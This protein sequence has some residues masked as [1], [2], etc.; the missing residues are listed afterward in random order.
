VGF[1]FWRLL[2]F[3]STRGA[4]NVGILTGKYTSAPLYRL[5]T[6][7]TEWL[8]DL[9]DA[10]INAWVVPAYNFAES[11]RLRE[12]IIS[13]GLAL[14]A[15]MITLLYV[16]WV[17]S[18]NGSAESSTSSNPWSKDALIL[19]FIALLC[20]TLPVVV[21][22]RDIRFASNYDR[23]TLQSSLGVALFLGGLIFYLVRS[24]WSL[25]ILCLM[26]AS[27]IA[28]HYNNASTFRD[29]W[30]IE[31]QYWWQM[32]WRAP[33]IK[34]GT[35][36][37]PLFHSGYYI[38]EDY[39]VWAPANIIYY[40][41]QR[42]VT[43]Q[44]DLV[45]SDTI[46]KVLL[47]KS[48]TNTT[49]TIEYARDFNQSLLAFI[50]SS[51]SCLHVI[52]GKTAALQPGIDPRLQILSGYSRIDQIEAEDSVHTPPAEIFGN[53]PPHT[54]CYYFQKA[55]LAEQQG[56]WNEVARLGDEARI[57][58]YKPNDWSEWL[59]FLEG[60][61]YTGN[62]DAARFLIP[63]LQELPSIQE[64]TCNRIEDEIKG[65]AVLPQPVLEGKRYLLSD[66]CKR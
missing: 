60:Y 63:I 44:T 45:N 33:Q 39:E 22:D 49:R 35:V 65:S 31:K 47:G 7:S 58:G 29:G 12:F 10:S 64:E 24:K 54:W 8:R 38:E 28:T 2:I 66:F 57:K 6:T 17:Y 3:K 4:T 40:P 51:Q 43:I 26:I 46:Q 55:S 61:A 5:L 56:N 21:A 25:G 15:I 16:R 14:L 34:P 9:F 37:L 52:D 42:N 36:L 41:R 48:D 13:L 11:T 53:E 62:F 27:A 19:G 20:T 30:T 32:S 50:P 1:L 18:K 23:Y 59:P